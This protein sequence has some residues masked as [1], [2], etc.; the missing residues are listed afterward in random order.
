MHKVSSNRRISDFKRFVVS[1]SS[2]AVHLLN[3][4]TD[5]NLTGFFITVLDS[6]FS[7]R[8]ACGS[9]HC[10]VC[11]ETKM[12]LTNIYTPLSDVVLNP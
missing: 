7:D 12:S 3:N 6:Q 9:N 5:D 2:F 1:L 8:K 4:E 11:C 10:S